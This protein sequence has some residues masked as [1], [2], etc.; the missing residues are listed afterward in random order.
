MPFSSARDVNNELHRSK[1]GSEKETLN[2][3]ANGSAIRTWVENDMVSEYGNENDSETGIENEKV[4]ERA[5]GN[6]NGDGRMNRS[7]SQIMYV[8]SNMSK[9][10]FRTVFLIQESSRLGHTCYGL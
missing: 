9:N 5:S 4:T 8:T 7:V 3:R 1:N 2:R 10:G 6:N